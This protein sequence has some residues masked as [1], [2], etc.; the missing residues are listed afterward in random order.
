MASS[1]E[2]STTTVV[3]TAL[4]SPP[5][6]TILSETLSQVF[7]QV[8][9]QSLPQ[10]LAAFQVNGATNSLNSATVQTGGVVHASR[11]ATSVTS[12]SST[13][14]GNIAVASFISTYSTVG[15]PVVSA[16][17][18]AADLS[19]FGTII[20]CFSCLATTCNTTFAPSVGKAFEVGPDYVPVPAKLGFL[21]SWLTG[22][23]IGCFSGAEAGGVNHPHFNLDPGLYHLCLDL[24]QCSPNLLAGFNTVQIIDPADGS[25]VSRS[26][27]ANLQCRLQ[28]GC[29]SI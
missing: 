21:L 27:L 1:G 3:K 15:I 9:G 13:T 18:Q 16:T 22:W 20:V 6:F 12:S 14:S 11:G 19:Y 23:E 28:E 7:L 2:T 24:L 26:G 4:A 8:L 17:A 25:P 5:I 10:I 29:C